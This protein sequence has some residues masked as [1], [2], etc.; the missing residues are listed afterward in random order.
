MWPIG[1]Q[2]PDE[3][4]IMKVLVESHPSEIKNTNLYYSR[5]MLKLKVSSSKIRAPSIVEL[6]F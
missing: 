3:H 1:R 5:E 6:I 4:K 2:D